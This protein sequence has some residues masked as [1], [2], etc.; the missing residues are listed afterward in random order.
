MTRVSSLV[1][2]V[3]TVNDSY[4]SALSWVGQKLQIRRLG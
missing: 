1:H 4:R 3:T 2:A